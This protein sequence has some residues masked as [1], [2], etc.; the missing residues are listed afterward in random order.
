LKNRTRNIFDWLNEITLYKSPTEK[1][2]EEDWENFNS[3]MV[4]RFISMNLY[5]VELANLAQILMPTNKQQIYNLYKELIPKRKVFLKYIKSKN[6]GKNK[7]LVE[8][9]SKYFK[10]GKA[11]V[12]S[13]IDI[14]GKENIISLLRDMGI[15][16]KE[17][18]K[19]MK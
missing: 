17:A 19:I 2:T 1:F 12:N 13:Y 14:L 15:E 4:H 11:E 3:Y 10:V 6:K 18:K 9:I 5:Y 8:K 7:E 16:D